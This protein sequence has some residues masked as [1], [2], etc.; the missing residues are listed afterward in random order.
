MKSLRAIVCLVVV[1]LLVGL[2][3]FQ[4]VAERPQ[5]R[6]IRDKVMWGDPDDLAGC[7]KAGLRSREVNGLP[8]CE[9][10]RRPMPRTGTPEMIPKL[11]IDLSW[12]GPVVVEHEGYDSRTFMIQV[13]ERSIRR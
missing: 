6:E 4:A 11:G 7:R 9:F 5:T 8:D 1:L 12:F 13:S 3:A 10:I 2:L